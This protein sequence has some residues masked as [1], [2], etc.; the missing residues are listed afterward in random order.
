MIDYEV[1]SIIDYDAFS[2]IDYCIF[3]NPFVLEVRKIFKEK[4]PITFKT[5]KFDDFYDRNLMIFVFQK[6]RRV[7]QGENCHKYLFKARTSQEDTCFHRQ[8]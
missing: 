3:H 7:F 6:K 1:S 2:I 4:N 8:I 5:K